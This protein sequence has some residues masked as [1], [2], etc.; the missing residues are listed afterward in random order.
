MSRIE[1]FVNGRPVRVEESLS[2][3]AALLNAGESCFRVSIDGA[4]R[5]PL[6]GMGT[7]HECRVSIDGRA[8]RRACLEP[9]VA[10]M[11]VVMDG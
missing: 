11:H 9:V 5:G 1:I 8:H 6:C 7:C 3:A 2:L 10:G 4:P